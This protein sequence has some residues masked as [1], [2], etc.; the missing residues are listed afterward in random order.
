MPAE[1]RE[2]IASIKRDL[3]TMKWMVAALWLLLLAD[4]LLL[5]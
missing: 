2:P 1:A 5:R 4:L 3:V